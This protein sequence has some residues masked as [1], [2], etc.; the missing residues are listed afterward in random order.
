MAR[1]IIGWLLLASTIGLTVTLLVTRVLQ[2]DKDFG[3]AAG[4]SG[5]FYRSVVVNDLTYMSGVLL[6]LLLGFRL[7]RWPLALLAR[8]LALFGLLIY[9]M[10]IVVAREF[11]A[12]LRFS[13]V[14][15][16]G[17]D[18]GLLKKHVE[19]TGL[20]GTKMWLGA[21]AAAFAL[22]LALL[23][24][25]L[26]V[27][28]GRAALALLGL[29]LVGMVAGQLIF[30]G[31]YV[32]D[33]G[34]RNVLAENLNT[35]VSKRYRSSMVRE[36]LAAPDSLQ[37]SPGRGERDDVIV[38]MVES[39]SPYQ[40]ALFGGGLNDWTPELDAIARSNAWFS[41]MYA[42]GFT[43]NEGLMG[44]LVGAELVAPV[45]SFFH[46]T[47]FETAW[48]VER[49]L[50][51]VLGAHGYRT[52]FL[53][54][55]NLSFTR[56]GEWLRDVGFDYVEGH[57]HPAYDGLPRLHFDSAPDEALYRRTLAH[58]DELE[59]APERQPYL[60]VIETVSSHHPH[61]H[62]HTGARDAE[63]VFRYTDAQAAAFY[64]ALQARG[65]FEH[66]SLLVIS[67]HRAMVPVGMAERQLLG[68]A[69][70]SRIPAFWAGKG[71]T[72]GE[73]SLP[74]HQA[75]LLDTLDRATADEF[76][77][78]HGVRDM[79]AP[80]QSQPRCLYHGRG[81]TRDLVDVFCPDGEGT[82]RLSGRKTAM[83]SA[84]GLSEVRAREVVDALN[85]YRIRADHHHEEWTRKA[86]QG[87][88]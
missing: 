40:S 15:Q 14:M 50:P 35:G 68:R 52:S 61:V 39:W 12:R 58:L 60:L 33:W 23:W 8:S 22:L 20:V 49:S 28:R 27:L 54:T 81:D 31:Q 6:L 57:D 77:G 17:S 62:P 11:F 73:V 44:L 82:I 56:K 30:P 79:L 1:E 66:G 19:N 53:T 26:R 47:P 18:L 48:G 75:D 43:T 86:A 87:G 10:D 76:C 51:R 88:G 24:P 36:A 78:R 67:D 37:C 3:G 55:G 32:H 9:A 84:E 83:E 21:G 25:S 5:C 42:A 46:A 85:R 70:L 34:V 71:V 72:P 16:F 7:S 41:R 29:A 59:S 2:V 4:C 65:Y 38:L 45:K 74:F 63:S 69:V 13:D 64:R 80:E